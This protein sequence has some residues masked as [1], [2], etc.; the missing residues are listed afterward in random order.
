VKIL[1]IVPTHEYKGYPRYLSISDFPTG[2]AYIAASLKKAGHEVVG[3]N[4]NNHNNYSSAKIMVEALIRT[5]LKDTFGLIGIGGLCVDYSCI[6]DSMSFIREL[7]KSP[8]VLGGG[9]MRDPDFIFS[10]LKP[11]YAIRHEAEEAIVKLVDCLE[12]N[13]DVSTV[14]NLYYWKDSQQVFTKENYNYCDINDLPFPDYDVFGGQEMIEKYSLFTRLTYRF[15]RYNPRL[16]VITTGRSCVFSCTFCVHSN[17]PKYRVRSIP[18]IMEELRINYDK[19]KFNILLIV[20]ELFAITSKRAEEFCIA[21]KENKEKYGWDFVWSFQTHA[22][23]KLDL[24][25]MKMMKDAG[26][27]FF[28]YGIESVNENVLKSMK[29]KTTKEQYIEAIKLSE[30]AGLSF[31]GNILIGDVAETIESVKENIE[32]IINYCQKA[33]IFVQIIQ[34]YPGCELFDNAEKKKRLLSKQEYYDK[35]GEVL[36]HLSEH[37]S[38]EEFINCTRLA[39]NMSIEHGLSRST[40]GKCEID[41]NI[42]SYIPG[43]NIYKITTTC[44]YC[45]K[46]MVYSNIN[47]VPLVSIYA[48]GCPHCGRKIRV[49]ML[50]VIM[51]M[52]L[53]GYVLSAPSVKVIK[54]PKEVI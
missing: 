32:F 21:L 13:K 25:T 44:P 39:E 45:E 5:T 31:G 29:K 49:E 2:L 7:T 1:L 37:L 28:S 46:S 10:N 6:K 54:E 52:N 27:F 35:M 41:Y 17:G 11:D 4:L 16:M 53:Q 43:L 23:S 22:N 9:I 47:V 33:F 24:E 15:P 38:L 19:Y 8:V 26:C 3:L 48:I 42:K 30:E 14:D 34:P 12:N 40:L 50:D 36:Y 51:N 18:N 20:D